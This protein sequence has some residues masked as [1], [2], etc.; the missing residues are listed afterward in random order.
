MALALAWGALA[1][2]GQQSTG[3]FAEAINFANVR[4]GIGIDTEIVTEIRA[5]TRYPV[6]GRSDAFP[7]VLIGD[8]QT[9]QPLGWV[10]RDLVTITGDL[11]TVPITSLNINALPTPT[12]S[13]TPDAF[14]APPAGDAPPADPTPT[15]T[16]AFDV[17]AVFKGEVN[18]RYGPGADY[19]RLGV[20]RAGDRLPIV[21]YHTQLEWVQVAYPSAPQGIAWVALSVI[22]VEGDFRTTQPISQTDFRNLPTLTPTPVLV[23]SSGVR[24]EQMPPPPSDELVELGTELWN[25]VLNARFDPATS[26]FGALYLKD[27]STGQEITFGNNYAFSGTSINK[28]GIL[29]ALYE[30]LNQE[31]DVNLAT[32]I[33]NM[34]ICSENVATNRVMSI[35]GGG[36]V[37]AGA[38][39]VTSVMERLGLTRSYLTAPYFIPGATPVPPTRPIRYPVTEADQRK[40]NP[41]IDNQ[42]TVDDMGF[43]LSSLY[44]CGMEERGPLLENFTGFTPQECRKMIHVMANNNTDALLKAGVPADVPVA[45]KHGWVD[46]THGN[47]AIFFTEGGDYVM[48]M[49]LHQP[50][51]MVYAESLPVIANTARLVYNFYNP[52]D[53]LSEPREGFIPDAVTCNFRGTPLINDLMDPFFARELPFEPVGL[54]EINPALRNP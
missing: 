53:A 43:L 24:R 9:F 51:W 15:P 29:L 48:V 32:D 44:Q 8:P 5:G 18:L 40:A 49:M 13:P 26:R 50:G 46:D 12:P 47:A 23:Q 27:L 54:G 11:N 42:M 30:L 37:Y 21:G 41:N 31:P 6:V 52:E 45:H 19:P 28:I 14:D 22:D 4:A 33:A 25:L 17:A 38:E 10:F 3:V 16:P 36:D 2:S 34:M 35:I 7:W 39:T 20:T 1:V